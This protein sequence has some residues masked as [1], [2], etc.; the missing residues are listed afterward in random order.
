MSFC[1][2][3]FDCCLKSPTGKAWFSLGFQDT[4]M[5]KM[6]MRHIIALGIIFP[7]SL[8]VKTNTK[9]W[10]SYIFPKD[11]ILMVLMAHFPRQSTYRNFGTFIKNIILSWVFLMSNF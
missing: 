2:A 8:L 5:Y 10:G 9:G 11:V 4:L 6:D 3:S 1:F 7:M